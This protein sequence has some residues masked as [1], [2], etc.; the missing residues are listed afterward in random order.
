LN[1]FKCSNATFTYKHE[2]ESWHGIP[3]PITS[4]MLRK[5][6]PV[7][8]WSKN[9]APEGGRRT[10]AYFKDDLKFE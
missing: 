7:F 10:R 8:Y 6:L 2:Y 9:E 3:E 1:V 4:G 5:T